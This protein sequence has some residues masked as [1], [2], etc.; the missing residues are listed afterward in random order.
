MAAEEEGR[1]I[2]ADGGVISHDTEGTHKKVKC[3]FLGQV[4]KAASRHPDYML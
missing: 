2:G 4:S 1:A 3:F